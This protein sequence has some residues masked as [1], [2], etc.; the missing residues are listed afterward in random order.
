MG[1][2]YPHVSHLTSDDIDY[3]LKIRGFREEITK[4]LDEKQRLLRRLYHEDKLEKKTYQSIFN[5]D[6]E[7]DWMLSHI[8]K[9]GDFLEKDPQPKYISRLRYFHMRANRSNVTTEQSETLKTSLLKVISD[10][11]AQYDVVESESDGQTDP[12]EETEEKKKEQEQKKKA[13]ESKKK[14]KN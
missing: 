3:E 12:E 13:E 2:K 11:V 10:L 5:I 8:E 1:L 14:N 7:H 6:Q 4:P 9:L